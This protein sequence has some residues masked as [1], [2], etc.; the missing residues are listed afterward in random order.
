MLD[1]QNAG[2]LIVHRTRE[3]LR[4]VDLALLPQYRNCGIGTELLRRVF[5]EAAATKK[6]L[7]LKVLKGNRAARLYQRLGF[8]PVG[9]TDLHLELEWRAPAG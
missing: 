5:G 3:T 9:E 8:A 2:R 4:I 6:P 7:R 1:G